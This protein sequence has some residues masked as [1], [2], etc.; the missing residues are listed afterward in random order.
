MEEQK[1]ISYL[2]KI[3]FHNP[4]SDQPHLVKQRDWAES[5]LRNSAAQEWEEP[6]PRPCG[7]IPGGWYLSRT[8]ETMVLKGT[9]TENRKPIAGIVLYCMNGHTGPLNRILQ[10]TWQTGGIG[11]SPRDAVSAR[12]YGQVYI[13]VAS[14]GV[15]RL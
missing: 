15:R 2:Q 3:P 13:D 9:I 14:I 5:D 8:V 1:Q 6:I 12:R 7:P 10:F 11:S 4:P